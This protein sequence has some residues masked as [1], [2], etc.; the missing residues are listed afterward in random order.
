[1]HFFSVFM[2]MVSHSHKILDLVVWIMSTP[3]HVCD[4]LVPVLR[5]DV[6][7]GWWMQSFRAKIISPHFSRAL[8][9]TH[10]IASGSLTGIPKACHMG[11]GSRLG[12]PPPQKRGLHSD[13]LPPRPEIPT[14]KHKLRGSND[15]SPNCGNTGSL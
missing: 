2:R 1:M 12:T 15:L 11:H 7:D 10:W 8:H 5:G 14:V 13:C 3:Q 4:V 6:A 9:P